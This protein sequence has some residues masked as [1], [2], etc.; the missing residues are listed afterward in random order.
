MSDAGTTAGASPEDMVAPEPGIMPLMDHLRE[1]RTRLIRASIALAI[2]TA[3]SFIFAKQVLVFLIAPMGE[4]PPQ[5]L[6]PTESLGN[7][8]KVALIS[9]VT[10]AMP[11]IVYQISR[12]IAPGLT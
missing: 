4:T 9:G 7:Y 3:F 11:V 8:M 2:T 1:L 10:L 12:F 5:A 6:K